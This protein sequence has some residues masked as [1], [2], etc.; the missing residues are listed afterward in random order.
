MADTEASLL[1]SVDDLGEVADTG[2]FAA[3]HGLDHKALVGTIKSL[4]AHELITNHR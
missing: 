4:M 3:Q 1:R 2:A